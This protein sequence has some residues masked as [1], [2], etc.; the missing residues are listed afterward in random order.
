[1][2]DNKILFGIPL[3]PPI[4]HRAIGMVKLK[5]IPY[6]HAANA[7]IQLILSD[8]QKKRLLPYNYGV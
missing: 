6:S 2:I 3:S 1:M 4:D 5:S 8:S 7:F